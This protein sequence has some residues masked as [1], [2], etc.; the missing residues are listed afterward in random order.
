MRERTKATRRQAI[1]INYICLPTLPTEYWDDDK[2]GGCATLTSLC[3]HCDTMQICT[4]ITR[5]SMER[6]AAAETA[7]CSRRSAVEVQQRGSPNWLGH[8]GHRHIVKYGLMMGWISLQNYR[9]G[10]NTP[11][12][13]LTS[14]EV[15][16]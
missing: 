6:L 7:R 13:V 5:R 15:D 2:D 4:G 9:H 8:R 1:K 16:F 3:L 12:M 14:T 10:Y 11:T